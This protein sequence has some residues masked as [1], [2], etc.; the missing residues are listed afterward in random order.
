[1]D[2]TSQFHSIALKKLNAMLADKR[3]IRIIAVDAS[4]ITMQN[5]NGT[6][7]IDQ[8]GRVKNND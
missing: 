2:R 4:G 5:K 7:K 1:M 6:Q 3:F 8:F